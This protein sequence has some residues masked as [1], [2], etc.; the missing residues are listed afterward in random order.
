MDNCPAAV[1]NPAVLGGAAGCLV[2]SALLAVCSLGAVPPLQY[3]VRYN[4]F[5]KYADIDNVYTA[6]RHFIGPFNAFVLFPSSTQTVEFVNDLS[7]SA[8][9]QRFSALHTRTKEGLA[10]HMQVSLQYRLKGA[11]VGKLYSEF[12]TFYEDMFISTIR[13]TLIQTAAE[14]EAYQLWTQRIQVGERMQELVNEALGK[15]YAECWGLQLMTIELPASFDKSIVL[16]QVQSQKV[17]TMRYDQVATKIR[18]ETKVIEAEYD[19]NVTVIKAYGKANYT[20]VTRSARAEARGK[21]LDTESVVMNTI[22]MELALAGQDL[23]EYQQFTAIQALSN[24][25]IFFGFD[26]GT[27]VLLQPPRR[28]SA[29]LEQQ[30][31]S[32]TDS[33]GAAPLPSVAEVASSALLGGATARKLSEEL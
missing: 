12:N 27:Q 29:S 8:E 11:E 17:E 2:L 30:P 20:L 7:L 6:G 26:E 23:V 1:E 33:G 9:G 21:T 24:A 32:L 14:Y 5:N 22:K 4:Y 13:D 15:T 19:R 3:G 25:S 16:T 18:A 31:R 10:L 28:L